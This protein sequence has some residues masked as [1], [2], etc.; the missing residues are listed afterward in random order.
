MGAS[1]GFFTFYYTPCTN[2]CDI[3]AAKLGC[4]YFGNHKKGGVYISHNLSVD[5]DY[6]HNDLSDKIIDILQGR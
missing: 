5:N 2:G 1:C 3:Y 6:I 4:Y